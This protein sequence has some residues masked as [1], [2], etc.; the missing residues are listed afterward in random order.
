MQK[1]DK[2]NLESKRNIFL[3]TGLIISLGLSLLAFEWKSG[4][5]SLQ[6]MVVYDEPS[7]PF[8]PEDHPIEIKPKYNPPKVKKEKKKDITVVD[9]LKKIVEYVA[10]TTPLD[11]TAFDPQFPIDTG[12]VDEGFALVIDTTVR[13]F[14]DRPAEFPGGQK[15][16]I[17]FIK[18]HVVY[19][20]ECIVLGIRES[21]RVQFVVEIDG[22]VTQ[23]RSI[24]GRNRSLIRESERVVRSLPNW[25]PAELN[26]QLVRSY[27]K[28]PIRY[29]SSR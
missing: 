3:T 8:G 24:Y 11:L 2:T 12:G 29:G 7:D 16:L 25:K 21:I 1:K 28:L 22:S 23:V 18:D 13:K 10:D 17:K 4:E 26:G 6:E 27:F 14:V 5:L 20:E 15:A 9:T 19:P